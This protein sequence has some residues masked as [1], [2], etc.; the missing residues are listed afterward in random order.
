[1]SRTVLEHEEEEANRLLNQWL[2]GNDFVV[3]GKSVARVD[4]LDKVLGKLKYMEDYFS[5]DMLF[6]R[7]V[8]SE[9]SSAYLEKVDFTK[10]ATIQGF[11]D[12]ITA[13]DV[14]GQNQVGYFLLDQPAF[15]DG[16]IRFRGEPVGL[17]LAKT[18]EAAEEASRL[19]RLE[20]RE[21]AAVFDPLEA[22]KSSVLVHEE[23][24]SNVA[25]TTKVRKGDAEKGFQ[26]SDVVVENT[27]RTGYQDHAPIE[28]EGAI[29]IPTPEGITVIS[30]NQHPAF[31]QMIVARVL[32]CQQR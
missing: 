5:K 14:T 21:K 31:A 30:C 7:I 9:V 4:G 6:A 8:K 28:P 13:K 26:E 17:A 20:H 1:M 2:H 11:V 27:Y 23:R 12:G 24:K 3:V 19:V 16:V 29:A 25:F 15:A 10:A 32:G 22:I 18:P